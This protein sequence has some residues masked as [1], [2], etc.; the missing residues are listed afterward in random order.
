MLKNMYIT[1]L[2]ISLSLTNNVFGMSTSRYA[3]RAIGRG[4]KEFSGQ[5]TRAATRG[6]LSTRGAQPFKSRNWKTA[7]TAATV[8]APG[9]FVYGGYLGAEKMYQKYQEENKLRDRVNEL[10]IVLKEQEAARAA[11]SLFSKLFS[12][13]RFDNLPSIEGLLAHLKFARE[14]VMGYMSLGGSYSKQAFDYAYNQIINFIKTLHTFG[15][16]E[17]AALKALFNNSYIAFLTSLEENRIRIKEAAQSVSDQFFGL[18]QYDKWP[19]KESFLASL[20]SARKKMVDYIDQGARGLDYLL[21]E[22]EEVRKQAFDYAYTKMLNFAK[23]L[24]NFGANQLST[25]KSVFI[26]AYEAAL[27]QALMIREESVVINSIEDAA[28]ALTSQFFGLIRYDKWPT[29]EALLTNLRSA[30]DSMEGYINQGARGLDYALNV[31]DKA[32]RNAFKRAYRETITF[33]KT[34]NQFGADQLESL[35]AV[36]KKSYTE[37]LLEEAD[38]T[39]MLQQE[40]ELY[41]PVKSEEGSYSELPSNV[42][43]ELVEEG[44]YTPTEFTKPDSVKH[45]LPETIPAIEGAPAE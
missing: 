1:I 21:I 44:V 37:A 25:L 2:L 40:L 30:K 20:E 23:T 33:A 3:S 35:K 4:T 17:L 5:A 18:I 45:K 32:M 15:A 7:R 43:T 34:L 41:Y 13:L 27:D 11:E 10:E 19:S 6:G 36:F 16:T 8:L 14:S 38:K 29:R 12:W 9:A 39:G 42:S 24:H 26:N 31:G 28:Q 22:G